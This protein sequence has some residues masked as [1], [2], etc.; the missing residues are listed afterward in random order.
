MQHLTFADKPKYSLAILVNDIRKDLIVKEYLKPFGIAEENVLVL[1][2]HQST[3]KKKTPVAEI[4][5]YIET[6]LR[7]VLDDFAVDFVMITD[8]AYFKVFAEQSK[9]DQ[10]TGYILDDPKCVERKVFYAPNAASV[11]YNPDTVRTKI[12]HSITA[13]MNY[14]DGKYTQPGDSIIKFAAYP[15][16]PDEIKHWLDKL[17]AMN[18]PLTVDIEGWSLKPNSAGIATICFCW[19]QH[20]GIAFPVDCSDEHSQVIRLLLRDFFERMQNTLIYHNIA[21]DVS[22]LVY[23]LYMSNITDT[24]G[25]LRGLSVLLKNWHDTKLIAYLATNSCAGNNLSLK[26]QAQEFAGNYALESISDITR[27][28]LPELLE[29]NLVDGLS[30]WYVFNKHWQ[31]MVDDQQLKIY[32]TIF[33]PAIVDIV[34]M[35][36]TGLPVNMPKVYETKAIL[37][38][39]NDRAIDDLKSNVVVQAFVHNL[40]EEWVIEKNNTLKKKRVT[41]ADAQ[42]EFNPNSGPQ[43]QALLYEHLALP[44]IAKT[45]SKAPA[46]N[47][48]TIQAL[49]HHTDSD[50]V[51]A[52]LNALLRFKAVN[53][54]LTAFIPA[55]EKAKPGPDGWHYLLGNFNLGGTVSGRLSSSEPNLQNLP[56]TGS[57]YAKL[58]KECFSA[59]AGWLFCG[60][61]FNSLEDRISAL[62]TK[63]PEKLKVYT[64]GYDGHCLRA[65]AYFGEHMPDIDPNSVASINT[66]ADKYGSYRQSSKAPTFAL[67]Y[68]GTYITLVKNCG[69]TTELAKLIEYRY[70]LLYTVS[71]MVIAAHLT[72]ASKVGYIEAAFGLR[73]RTPLLHQTIRGLRQT[74]FEAEAE[75]RTAGNALGQSWCLLNSRASSE[76]MG[77]VRASRYCL[78]IRICAQIHD[79][80]Y[81]LIKDDIKTLKYANDN[82]VQACEWQDDPAI[83][84]DDVKLGGGFSVFFPTWANE[85]HIPNY[86]D[87]AGIVTAVQDYWTKY[88]KKLKE[89]A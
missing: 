66:I 7:P 20:E 82:V 5:E 17:I 65:Y 87:E 63:D 14:V 81:Y 37:Q 40:K 67:T 68:Q 46:T 2:L 11:F 16:T 71:D 50:D 70:H 6:E 43:L 59:P 64:D 69:F 47:G 36:L 73:V 76:F 44:V 78:N 42:I 52:F 26:D 8:P 56:A 31:T 75:G 55:F 4:K 32:R 89:A 38:V 79:A 28:P 74:P 49:V 88:Q 51:K 23:Q 57:K 3:L 12:R 62:T 86:V 34:Q 84:H 30:T 80:Q 29:Y 54:I 72:K 45:K 39:D 61:D 1:T 58:I 10:L 27:V 83:Y 13:L 33:K 85:C 21:F 22:V 60:I 24:K 48:D 19:N 35:Q 18:C 9:A 77:K 41:L 53:K 15:S 25:L